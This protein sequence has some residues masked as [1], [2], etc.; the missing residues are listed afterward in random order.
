MRSNSRPRPLTRGNAAPALAALFALVA[1]PAVAQATT[2]V[3]FSSGTGLHLVDDAGAPDINV[4][5]QSGSAVSY[6]VESSQALTPSPPC[7]SQQS[8][9]GRSQV[10]CDGTGSTVVTAELGDG[11]DQFNASACRT[12]IG[13][14]VVSAGGGSDILNGGPGPDLLNGDAGNDTLNGCT[15]DDVVNGGRDNDRLI[16]CKEAAT[17]V[18][19]SADVL[20]G[21]SGF[22]IVQYPCGGSV[23]VTLDDQA[24]DGTSGQHDNIKSDIESVTG[25]PGEDQLFGSAS[26]FQRLDGGAGADFIAGE[27]ATVTCSATSCRDTLKGGD[28]DDRLEGRGGDDALDGELGV[29][30]LFGGDGADVLFTRDGVKDTTVSCGAG[31]D[32][33]SVDLRDLPAADCENIDQG[34]VK[35]GPNVRIATRAV[36]IDGD[37]RGRVTLS[38]PRKLSRPC[39]GTLSLNLHRALPRGGSVTRYSVKPGGSKRVAVRLSRSDRRTL[40]N[41]R[42]PRGRVVS[43]EAGLH[44]R[45]TTIRIVRLSR[46]R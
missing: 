15:G 17:T 25:G 26:N 39:A 37:G 36:V 30:R 6:V 29:D 4:V 28:G 16:E 24:N 27:H 11:A 19:P 40:A 41:Q 13:D 44:G 7:V 42:K 43:L 12:A 1:L 9:A 20:S 45:K 31:T 5:L 34:A 33:A 35:E 18:V 10:N 22:D 3:S 23:T 32:T 46:K 38:C 21:G 2:A 14:L 8:P